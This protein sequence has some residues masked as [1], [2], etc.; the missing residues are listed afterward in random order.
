MALL[1]TLRAWNDFI[2]SHYPSRAP[3]SE[4]YADQA[5]ERP[6][7]PARVIPVE[8]VVEAIKVLA[9]HTGSSRAALTK[10]FKKKLDIGEGEDI[11]ISLKRALDQGV[12]AGTITQ[13]RQSFKVK[14]LEFPP[15]P[16]TTVISEV[17]TPP[18]NGASEKVKKGHT[19]EVAYEGACSMHTRHACATLH[20]CSSALRPGR[21]L[22]GGTVF[23]SAESFSFEVGGGEVIRGWDQGVIGMRCGE[24]RRLTIPPK[25]GYGKR[26]SPPEVP[27]DATLVFDITLIALSE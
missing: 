9:S 16:E 22:E 10:F 23:D 17:L 1:Y 8:D 14:G 13:E 7:A 12:K 15:P 27:P 18:A 24:K 4:D 6:Q 20:S 2:T 25:L 26:G 19:V 3:M 21:L 11:S 5:P